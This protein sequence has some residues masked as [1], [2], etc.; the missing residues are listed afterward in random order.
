MFNKAVE[1]A[2]VSPLLRNMEGHCLLMA[3][4]IKG[5]INRYVKLPCKQ[6][7]LSVGELEGI[8]LPGCFERK[9]KCIW[10]SCLDPEESKILSLGAI[11]NFD[12]GTGLS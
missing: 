6:I 2:S 3:F 4:E 9:G 12:K 7:S 8:R 5:Y 1:W 11:W 10:V